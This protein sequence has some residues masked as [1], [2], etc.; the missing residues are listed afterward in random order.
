[1]KKRVAMILPWAGPLPWYFGLFEASVKNAGIDLIFIRQTAEYFKV[2]AEQA[3]G[4]PVGLTTGYKL[5]DLR[6]MF[7]EI[8]AAEL[9]GYD[10]WASGDCDVVFGRKMGEWIRKMTDEQWDVACVHEGWATG[11]F[12]LMRNCAEVNSLYRRA[13]NWPAV[14]ADPKSF[15]FDELG[16]YNWYVEYTVGGK[17]LAQLREEHES[18]SSVLWSASDLRF[19]HGEVLCDDGLEFGEQVRMS[20]D[21]TLTL[22]GAEIAAFHFI[23]VKAHLS[24][25]GPRLSAAEVRDWTLTKGGYFPGS[26]VSKAVA[27]VRKLT[28]LAAFARDWLVGRPLVRARVRRVVRRVI[29]RRARWWEDD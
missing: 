14:V 4:V 29:L 1:M 11:P 2:R 21:G 18:L 24:F 15:A 8:F 22:R 27:F 9:S 16:C 25:R 7:G 13:K 5:C 12:T 26:S 17:T 3:L 6:P 28:G 23:F 19:W 20:P 10:Y